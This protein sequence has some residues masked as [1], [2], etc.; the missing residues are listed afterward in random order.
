MSP[1][2]R[3]LSGRLQPFLPVCVGLVACVVS[4]QEPDSVARSGGAT[5]IG[6]VRDSLARRPL[7]GAWVQL[8]A[9]G[10]AAATRSH[11]SDSLGRFAFDGVPDGRY[12]LGFFHPLLDSLGVEAPLRAVQ[13]KGRRSVHAD[14]AIPAPARLRTAICDPQAAP[15]VG[16]THGAVL[17]GVVRDARERTPAAGVRVVGEWIEM[18]FARGSIGRR[19]AMLTVTTAENGWFALCNVPSRGSMFLSASRGNDSTD[20]IELEMPSDGFL[21]RELFL[22]P[23]RTMVVRD[24]VPDADTLTLLPRRL[25]LGEGHLRGTVVSAEGHRPLSG[26][27]VRISD[28]TMARADARGEWTIADAPAGTRVLEARAVG[29]SPARVAVDIVENA[30]PVTIELAD[31]K[32]L[33]DTVR[34]TSA[35]AAD[36]GLGGFESRRRSTIGRFLTPK[37]IERRGAL[38]TSD[39]F[40]Q[41]PM[42]RVGPSSDTIPTDMGQGIPPDAI[43]GFD[44]LILMHGLGNN[45]CAPAIF[46]DGSLIAGA[47]ADDVDS[48]VRP[49]KIAGVEVYTEVAV[50]PDFQRPRSGCGTVVIWRK[51]ARPLR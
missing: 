16:P 46:L 9:S 45:W 36:R 21:R 30:T 13:V 39:L 4:A 2:T 50:P 14:L 38:F 6:V 37:D 5:V 51:V 26:A 48:W 25:R 8:V 12:T 29:Y 34:I 42:V 7:A 49:E 23:A 3:G 24:T 10:R 11:Q 41:M 19:R 17:V 27:L 35:R 44:R 28:G 18:S 33:L 22:G 47:T 40:R 32:S 20:V 31:F 1:E 15:N 43:I